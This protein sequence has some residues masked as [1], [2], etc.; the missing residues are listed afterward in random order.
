MLVLSYKVWIMR[1]QGECLEGS[2]ER[3]FCSDLS[4]QKDHLHHRQVV[5]TLHCFWED[6]YSLQCDAHLPLLL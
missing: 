3:V 1:E 5:Y 2:K 4:F 6:Y